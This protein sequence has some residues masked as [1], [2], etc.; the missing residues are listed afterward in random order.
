MIPHL[1]ILP[2]LLLSSGC[3]GSLTPV[4][5]TKSGPVQGEILNTAWN[6]VRYSSFKGIPYGQPPVGRLRYR[7][8][9]PAEPWRETLIANKEENRCPQIDAATNVF[10]GDEDC[11]Y[12]NVYTPMTTF[13]KGMHKHAVMLWIHG[14]SN[15]FGSKNASEYGPDLLI[16]QGIVLVSI[17]YRLGAL[18]F[19]SLGREEAAGNA[20]LKDQTLALRWVQENIATFGGDPRRVT[21]FG[22]SSGSADVNFHVL[23]PKSNGLF[24][25]AIFMSGTALAPWAYYTPDQSMEKAKQLASHLG[26]NAT[27]TNE[28]LH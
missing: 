9:E 5:R 28:L 6:A 7:P 2:V 23:S 16:E 27:N 26:F 13:R 21:I 24:A 8:P 4:I 11:L 22:Q 15:T 20:G 10:T 12:L 18:G 17:N 1:L 3:M 25:R 14:G 19:L